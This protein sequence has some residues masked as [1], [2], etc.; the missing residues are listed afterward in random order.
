MNIQKLK[1]VVT[2]QARKEAKEQIDQTKK[3]IEIQ[4]EEFMKI[5]S[6][7]RQK[8]LKEVE[9]TFQASMHQA[10][11]NV[12]SQ[13]K[14]KVLHTRH[15]LLQKL[16]S[17]LMEEYL[18]SVQK[19]PLV[20]LKS[21]VATFPPSADIYCS[22]ELE[23]AITSNAIASVG[24]QGPQYRF[25]GVDPLLSPGVSCISDKVKYL[26]LLE[27]EIDSYLDKHQKEFGDLIL[28]E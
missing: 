25:C 17:K 9:D 2:N 16:K 14:K 28:H 22:K 12:E 11:F 15:D 19:D 7:D 6:E 24:L 5:L 18:L 20:F 21:I 4:L 26:F 27:E 8:Q 10:E 23:T 13:F 1:E 3:D